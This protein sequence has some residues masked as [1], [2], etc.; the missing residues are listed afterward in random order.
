MRRM[1]QYAGSRL[2]H[3]HIADCYNHLANVGNRHIVNP[4]G[5]DARVHQ[6]NEIGHGDVAWDEFFETLRETEFDGVATVCVFGWEED[7]DGIHRRM[8][9]CVKSELGV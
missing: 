1:L 6:H 4:P 5:A 2:K 8:L 7:A 3:V 9:E